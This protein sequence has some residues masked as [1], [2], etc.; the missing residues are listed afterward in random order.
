MKTFKTPSDSGKE[1]EKRVKS[2]LNEFYRFVLDN[3]NLEH[4]IELRDDFGYLTSCLERFAEC[5]Q[6]A[7]EMDDALE[8]K[9]AC[10][11]YKEERDRRE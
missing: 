8:G 5:H 3:D 1:V 7:E 2:L 10:D 9:D 11:L 4:A 6:E